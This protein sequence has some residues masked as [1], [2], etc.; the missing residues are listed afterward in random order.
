MKEVRKLIKELVVPEGRRFR[1]ESRDP[2]YTGWMKDG[3]EEAAKMLADRRR[4]RLGPPGDAIARWRGACD[5]VELVPNVP[6]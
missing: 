2:S 5:V 4:S 3:D 1:L 6:A